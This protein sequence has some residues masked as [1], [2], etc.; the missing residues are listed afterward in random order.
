[1]ICGFGSSREHGDLFAL[2]WVVRGGDT[3][4]GGALV[5]AG[6]VKAFGDAGVR[7]VQLFE[8]AGAIAL[9]GQM[10]QHDVR[11]GRVGLG[12]QVLEGVEGLFVGQVAAV[13]HDAVLE[14]RGTGRVELH[15]R[16]VVG[17]DGQEMDVEH[18]VKQR[19]GDVAEIG[20]VGQA[21]FAATEDVAGGALRIVR[22]R[23][24]ADADDGIKGQL[25]HEGLIGEWTNQPVTMKD[26]RF[27]CAIG[28][29]QDLVE[30]GEMFLMEVDG[31]LA[32]EEGAVP[33]GGKVIAVEVGQEDGADVAEGNAGAVQTFGGGAWAEPG[34]DEDDVIDVSEPNDGTVARRSAAENAKFDGQNVSLREVGRIIFGA[35]GFLLPYSRLPPSLIVC[36]SAAVSG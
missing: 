8:Q 1:M 31:D 7:G 12:E 35:P 11:G 4:P 25:E 6:Q 34:V 21:V 18:G 5:L 16:I 20:G 22:E 19:V 30:L 26:H 29:S 17:F 13:G 2:Q 36:R 10:K 28:G 24:G 32:F 27:R 33:V 23:D 15:P 3:E 14:H 9:A